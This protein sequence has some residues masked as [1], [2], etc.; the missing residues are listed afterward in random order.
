MR[1]ACIHRQTSTASEAALGSRP[2]AD[3]DPQL[4]AA[5]RANIGAAREIAAQRGQRLEQPVDTLPSTNLDSLDP[6][7]RD[8]VDATG[9]LTQ[10]VARL[11]QLVVASNPR[12]SRPDSSHDGEAVASRAAGRQR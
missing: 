6:V 5:L 7:V 10:A 2:T 11:Q 3:S 9:M 8:L 4:A 1:P 12:T